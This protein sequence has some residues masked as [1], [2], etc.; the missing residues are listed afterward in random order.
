MRASRCRVGHA[1][2][3]IERLAAGVVLP[4]EVGDHVLAGRAARE[5]ADVGGCERLVEDGAPRLEVERAEA[6]AV[7]RFMSP[8]VGEDRTLL[9]P[10]PGRAGWQRGIRRVAAGGPAS[11]SG[12][13]IT[14]PF[15]TPAC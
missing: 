9:Y 12:S 4:H 5:G 11:L 1:C 7:R 8:P 14:L 10:R 3:R 2:A 15:R 6:V 13:I